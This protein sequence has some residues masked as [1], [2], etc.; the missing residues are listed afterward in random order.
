MTIV[1]PSAFLQ[2]GSYTAQNDRL[3][4]ITGRYQPATA[5]PFDLKAR[6][7][8]LSNNKPA[9]W[10][11]NV[12][13]AWSATVAPFVMLVENDFATNAGDYIVIKTGNDV[14]TFTASSP[15]TNRI[16]TIAVQ[17]VDAFYSGAV[18]EGRLVVVEGTATTGTPVPPTLPSSCEPILDVSIAAGST[19]PVASTDRRKMSALMGAITPIFTNQLTDPGAYSGETQY[20]ETFGTYRTWRQSPISD[21]RA[22]GGLLARNGSQLATTI[23]LADG[24][25]GN[26]SQVILNDPGGIWVALGSMQ[27]EYTWSPDT[28][29][30]DLTLGRNGINNGGLFA[31]TL[32]VVSNPTF[33]VAFAQLA[34]GQSP[35]LTGTQTIW[36]NYIRTFGGAA[37]VTAT[38]FNYRASAAQ[39][40]VRAA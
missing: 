14:V 27:A 2:A 36:F 18:S 32:P 1:N 22:F 17:V 23:P 34:G 15:T 25:E 26:S 11:I 13:P 28:A 37:T 8:L 9:T 7:G 21:W 31:T 24:Q 38:P 12:S 10:A 35:V 33:P 20:Y 5:V 16:D 3:H 6:G 19:A 29:R 30:V 39:L 40:L 4:Q